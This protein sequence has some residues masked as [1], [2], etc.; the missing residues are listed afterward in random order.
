MTSKI[1]EILVPFRTLFSREAA[2]IWFLVIIIGFL[3]RFD[4]YGVSSFIRWLHLS[5]TTYPLLIHFFHANSWS[6][7][8][9]MMTWIDFSINNFPLISHN[10]R[11]LAVGDGIKIPK[12]G[13]HQPGIKSMHSPSQ[14][15][16]K[17]QKFKGHH[18]G[19]IAFIANVANHFRAILQVAQIHEGVDGIRQLQNTSSDNEAQKTIVSRMLSL[20]IIIAQSQKQPLYILLDAFFA[21]SVA[22]NYIF[23]NV[24]EN[25]ELWVHLITR[26]KSNYVAYSTPKKSNKQKVKLWAVFNMP[27]SFIEAIHPLYPNRTIKI[28][29][30]DLY[31][32]TSLFLI[33]FVWVIDG[34]SKFILM[35]S[36]K[37]LHPLIILKFYA[38]RSKI[39]WSFKILKHILGGFCYRFWIM[40]SD[41][42]QR[43]SLVGEDFLKKYL[44]KLIAIERYVNL[45][46][47]AQGIL[48]FL[49]LTQTEWVW[50]IHYMSSWLRTYSST[51]PSEEVVQRALQS[52]ELFSFSLTKLKEWV[53]N[54]F[55]KTL[56]HQSKVPKNSTLELFML[57]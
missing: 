49:A 11:I 29:H 23:T 33:R 46:I 51:I 30:D 15:Q 28:C 6:L 54:R 55:R 35:S 31:W 13:T 21:T 34:S 8:K 2:Y 47:I 1:L 24:Q 37:S 41:T 27:D 4:H 5:E 38:L 14:N 7:G 22:F 44:I 39:E 3:L 56:K 32:G 19:C 16:N 12:E 36:D 50:K 52:H 43:K 53:T 26:A 17:P 18:F 57:S 40:I 10:G 45:A 25:G 48:S 9:V 20:I 42:V